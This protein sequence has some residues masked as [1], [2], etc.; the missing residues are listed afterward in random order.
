MQRRPRQRTWRT[1]QPF[2]WPRTCLRGC[3]T[4]PW[5][6]LLF[7]KADRKNYAPQGLG[8]SSQKARK[9]GWTVISIPK[10]N[11][12]LTSEPILSP[13]NTL[14]MFPRWLKLKITIGIQVFLDHEVAVEALT[15]KP[16]F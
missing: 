5:R 10:W 9:S 12:A 7:G 14:R 13:N 1:S 4:S 8:P 11:Y 15:F 6:G 3:A 16:Y 2:F